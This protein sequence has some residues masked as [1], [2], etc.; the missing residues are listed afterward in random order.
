MLL[1]PA[2]VVLAGP[3]E[4][5]LAFFLRRGAPSG[6][7]KGAGGLPVSTYER[8]GLEPMGEGADFSAALPDCDA[9]GGAPASAAGSVFAEP[10]SAGGAEDANRSRLPGRTNSAIGSVPVGIPFLLGGR[11][12]SSDRHTGHKQLRSCTGSEDTADSERL[13][14][15]FGEVAFR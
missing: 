5:A 15:A 1:A 12:L 2:S 7:G 8:R 11:T 4:A 14:V 9:F 6:R 3:P 13:P 10:R